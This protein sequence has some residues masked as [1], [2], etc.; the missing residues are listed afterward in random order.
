MKRTLASGVLAPAIAVLFGACAQLDAP[1]GVASRSPAP[2]SVPAA[3]QLSQL[4]ADSDEAL[5]RRNPVFA[6]FRGDMRYAAQHGDYLSNAYVDAERAAA[7]DDLRRL[8]AI[9]R[10]WLTPVERIAYD[11][12]AWQHGMNLRQYDPAR[13]SVWLPLKLD[14]LNGWHLFFPDLSSGIGVAPYKTVA[15][16]DNGLAR[17]D[18]FVIYRERALAR[19]REGLARGVVQPRLVVEHMI[20]QFD[21]FIAQG[22]EGSTYYGPIRR[23]PG[24]LPLAERDRLTRAYAEA[25]RERLIPVFVRVRDGLRNELLPKAPAS[26]GLS[27]LPGGADYYRFLVELH[28][29]TRV[30]PE[31]I[32][33]LGLA[34][35]V[36]ITAAMQALVQHIGFA[37]TLEQFQDHLRTDARF[38]PS[39][40]AALGD[41]Y[42]DIGRRV[43]AAMPRLFATLP[44]TRLEIRP[45][46]GYQEKTDAGARYM[47]GSADGARAGVFFYN[48]YDLPSRA[49]FTMETLYLHEAVPGHHFQASLAQE[50]E[51]LP[52]FLRFG[53]YTAYDEGWALYAESLGPELG[54]ETDAYQRMGAYQAEMWRALRLVVDTGIHA[55]GWSRERAIDYML[56]HS[57]NSRTDT[58]AEVERYVVDPGQALAYKVGELTIRRL[59]NHAEAAFGPK[60]DL[61][62]FHRQMLDTGALPMDVLA[63]KIEGWIDVQQRR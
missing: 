9:D 41:G 20:D 43:D 7:Q 16:Y 22:V 44:K 23:L 11:S 59:R 15:D 34:E 50:N 39:S 18:G 33:R 28:T 56:A 32:H 63:A 10:T 31:E 6:L 52:K 46:P 35:V 24:E 60:F 19:A 51:A 54:M 48:T 45:T 30:T 14:H 3:V 8:D 27:Q 55:L 47:S 25:I 57:A 37:G 29:T 58:V 53:G 2:Q 61:R 5:L 4:L 40:A 12:F 17:I 21:A 1:W 42:R 26:V 62:E 38:K 36:R 13:V 49:T